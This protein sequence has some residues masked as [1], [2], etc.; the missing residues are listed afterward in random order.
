MQCSLTMG[1]GKSPISPMNEAI[2][3]L[4]SLLLKSINDGEGGPVKPDLLGSGGFC[5]TLPFWIIYTIW[6]LLNRGP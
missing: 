2:L 6:N 5:D 3:P 4:H 1:P